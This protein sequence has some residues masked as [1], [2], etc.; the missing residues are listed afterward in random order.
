M[1]TILDKIRK[2][3]KEHNMMVKGDAVVVGLSGGPDSVCMM[4]AL[5]ALKEELEIR[6]ICGV[7]INHGLRGQESDGDEAYAAHLCE[8]LGVECRIFRFD[9]AQMAKDLG[10][11]TE[12]AGRKVR[13][14][15]FEKVCRD[16]GGQ[17]IAVAHNF[18]DQA[19]TVLMR[20]MRGTGLSGLAG[21]P[22]KRDDGVIIRPV[23]DLKRREI[24][25]YC[26]K[27][28]LTPRIDSTN[29]KS[30][31]TRNRIRLELIPEMVSNYNPNI[32]GALVRLAK[33]AAEDNDFIQEEAHNYINGG[34]DNY[35]GIGKLCNN[36]KGRFDFE[37]ES[38]DVSGFNELHPSVAKRVIMTCAGYCGLEYNISA[39]NVENVIDLISSGIES[40]E[41]DISMG[42]YVRYSYGKLW[43]AQRKAE[44]G[45]ISEP[46]S[47]PIEDL[48]MKGRA[49]VFAG[50]LKIDMEVIELENQCANQIEGKTVN[51]C[52]SAGNGSSIKAVM[53]FDRLLQNENILFRNRMPGD[54]I[55]PKGMKGSKKLQD[56][57][58]DRKIPKHLRDNMLL[59][60]SG[61]KILLAGSETAGE[62]CKTAES[63]RIL[64][65]EY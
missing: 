15:S 65:I 50:G 28:G 64:T 54:R 45:K 25:E 7:H 44:D 35:N 29:K 5:C 8:S 23:L 51:V 52:R 60:V 48:L 19:E 39:V 42:F 18:N 41:V 20:I 13:Y 55:S 38:L 34:K 21:I 26:S 63:R 4:H 14:E 12:D 59:M 24:E 43:F 27:A 57:L 6:E 11:G 47:V 16:I 32:E 17:R 10:I 2:T 1:K 53:D 56:Y 3:I 61:G 62:C 36:S 30:I 46:V 22:Y 49:E 40:K 31:Y 33:Q 9:V 58:I 37:N